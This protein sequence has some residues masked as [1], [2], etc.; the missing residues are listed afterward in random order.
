MRTLSQQ[1]SLDDV[2]NHLEKNYTGTGFI[3]DFEQ[4]STLKAMQITDT[5]KGKAYFLHPNMM[6]WEYEKPDKQLIITDGISLWI[7]K[8]DENQVMIGKS[9]SFFG[10]GKG[11]SF[12]TNISSIREKFTISIENVDKANNNVVLRLIPEKSDLD[13]SYILITISLKTYYVTQIST[14]NSYEDETKIMFKNIVFSNGSD[15]NIF[16]FNIPEDADILSYDE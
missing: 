13:L 8:P 5:A 16:K 4:E 15:K 10:D 12:L 11:A 7:F 14:Y 1:A 2:L 6:R 9:P 3:V